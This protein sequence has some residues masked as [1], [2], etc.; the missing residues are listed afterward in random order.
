MS[1]F[2]LSTR[3]ALI[4]VAIVTGSIAVPVLTLIASS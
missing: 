1:D 3:A 2:I 4:T